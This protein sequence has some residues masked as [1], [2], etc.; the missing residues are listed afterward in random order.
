MHDPT[1]DQRCRS[2]SKFFELIEDFVDVRWGSWNGG[3]FEKFILDEV[4]DF[5]EYPHKIHDQLNRLRRKIKVAMDKAE[6]EQY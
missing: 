2:I 3:E 5:C 1:L 6:K 4:Y